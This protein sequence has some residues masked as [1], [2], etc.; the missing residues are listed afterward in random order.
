MNPTYKNIH[1]K[2]QLNGLYFNQ[3]ELKEV[4]YS[5]VKE[6]EPH[7][8]SVGDFLIDW[9]NDKDYVTVCTSG[10]TGTPKIIKLQKQHMV[11][12]AIATGDFF[13]VSVGDSALHCLPA[14]FIAGKMML[15]RALILG[16]SIDL[17]PPSGYPLAD[18]GKEYDFCA[19][20]PFQLENSIDRLNQIKTLIVGGAPVS[21]ELG[22]KLQGKR[23]TVYETYGMT[24][25]VTHIAAKKLNNFS[26]EETIKTAYFK[27][28]P[29]VSI[30]SDDR[31]CL[32]INAPEV[33]EETIITNDI[34]SIH[35]DDTFE[36][37]GRYDNI[38]NSGGVKLIPEQIE[39]KLKKIISQRFF[40]T[41]YPDEKLGQKL[42]LLI[43]D[44][45]AVEQ[46]IWEKIKTFKELN[47]FEIPKKIV[48]IDNF[49][50]T[51]NGKIIRDT[52]VKNI[53]T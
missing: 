4:A 23:T 6:G 50:E 41:G 3:E 17:V 7:E 19:M 10:S 31:N 36:W 48:F 33:S 39:A 24:E 16:L 22:K 8:R 18:N 2:F 53:L 13:G 38:I 34:V 5:F 37:L 40:V 15:V 26:L 51:E 21:N 42:V 46:S 1:L 35:S 25:T 44:D 52:T 11:N 9:L 29:N 30:S 32:V 49:K 12:S 47:K 45:E 20:I 27:A 14:T 28:L 43:E